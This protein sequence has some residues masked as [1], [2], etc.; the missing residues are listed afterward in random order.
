MNEAFTHMQL[1]DGLCVLHTLL[2]ELQ[3]HF[4]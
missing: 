1:G 4:E 3:R 2:H